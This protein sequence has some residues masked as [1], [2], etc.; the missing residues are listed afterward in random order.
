MPN[1]EKNT[2]NIIHS[3]TLPPTSQTAK[4]KY[5]VLAIVTNMNEQNNNSINTLS[6]TKQGIL[7]CSPEM[8]TDI[9]LTNHNHLNDPYI[10][11]DL[12]K[13]YIFG[14]C[15]LFPSFSI[16][17]HRIRS[18]FFLLLLNLMFKWKGNS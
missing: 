18:Y 7:Q 9:D 10:D 6:T 12:Y 13:S 15:L 5:P 14:K 8:F 3:T 17:Q 2:Q 4:G 16:A 11:G 1:T